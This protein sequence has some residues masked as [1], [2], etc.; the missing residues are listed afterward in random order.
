VFGLPIRPVSY[1]RSP[2]VSATAPLNAR[3]YFLSK[4]CP[5]HTRIYVKHVDLCGRYAEHCNTS[6]LISTHN[7]SYLVIRRFAIFDISWCDPSYYFSEFF[8]LFFQELS[9]SVEGN[10][11][12]STYSVHL[13]LLLLT[14]GS[15][16]KT[17]DELL[18]V[19]RLPKNESANYEKLKTVIENIEV[20]FLCRLRRV[21]Q[22]VLTKNPE[23]YSSI[24]TQ[25]QN[26]D[27]S[28]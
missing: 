13:L 14:L 3:S 24:E 15:R 25:A 20:S 8:F 7:S 16:S 19:L 18:T 4:N 28:V 23:R 11:F 5:F 10:L 17:N 1:A 9:T 27:N 6:N 22:I 21:V 12:A 2:D 26:Y